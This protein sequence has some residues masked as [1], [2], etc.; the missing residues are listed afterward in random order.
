[1]SF[2]FNKNF[3]TRAPLANGSSDKKLIKF[4]PAPGIGN[5]IAEFLNVSDFCLLH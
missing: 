2:G 4:F 3:M 1:M 5:L